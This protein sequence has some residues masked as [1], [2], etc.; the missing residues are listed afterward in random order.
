MSIDKFMR[1][2]RGVT[3]GH[4]ATCLAPMRQS[5]PT[6]SDV[7]RGDL[8]HPIVRPLGVHAD[9][10]LHAEG[11]D[12]VIIHPQRSANKTI[13]NYAALAGRVD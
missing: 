8:A 1:I 5:R 10:P 7:K 12:S 6:L 3:Y 9:P 2:S 4:S 13:Q 11:Q